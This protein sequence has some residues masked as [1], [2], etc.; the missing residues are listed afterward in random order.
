VD[1]GKVC[2]YFPRMVS[3]EDNIILIEPITPEQLSGV[4]VKFQKD[5][6]PKLYG[7]SIE[8][9]LI[10]FYFLGEDLL[11]VVEEVKLTKKVLS[12]FNSTFIEL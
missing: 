7:W 5:K 2:S 12:C 9:F 8:F 1:I 6:S 10:I 4:M 3:K 11:R